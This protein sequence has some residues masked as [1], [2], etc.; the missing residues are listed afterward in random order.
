MG[1]P[2]R[3]GL[4]QRRPKPIEQHPATAKAI[5][6]L[7]TA[8]DKVQ[9]KKRRGWKCTPEY[10]LN[11]ITTTERDKLIKKGLQIPKSSSGRAA[12]SKA[13]ERLIRKELRKIRN[14]ASAQRHR[15]EQKEYIE[16]PEGKIHESHRNIEKLNVELSS[17]RAEK[18]AWAEERAAMQ[19][20]LRALR[21]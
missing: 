13:K 18:S 2:R 14:V 10:L 15:L 4:R 19:Q 20:Q 7:R 8:K 11:N 6:V 12:L 16:E 3:A 21:A 17:L 1:T 5:S 9:F